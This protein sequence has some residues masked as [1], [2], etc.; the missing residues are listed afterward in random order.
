MNR[1]IVRFCAA[2]AMVIAMF[3]AGSALARNAILSDDEI[4]QQIIADSIRSYPGNCACPYSTMRNGRRCGG[5]SA[6]RKPGGRAP[7]CYANDVTDAM[8]ARW[9]QGR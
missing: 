7:I 2:S 4:R 5:R 8:V 1:G 9:K 6:Y 3:L